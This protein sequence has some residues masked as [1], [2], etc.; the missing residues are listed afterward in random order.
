MKI[1]GLTTTRLQLLLAGLCL[2]TGT[3]PGLLSAALVLAVLGARLLAI[4]QVHHGAAPSMPA[5]P[6]GITVAPAPTLTHGRPAA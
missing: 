6:L 5:R 2:A 1:P 4:H 3:V